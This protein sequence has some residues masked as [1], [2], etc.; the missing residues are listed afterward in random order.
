MSLLNNL[1]NYDEIQVWHMKISY[2]LWEYP[3]YGMY[4]IMFYNCDRII[5][6]SRNHNVS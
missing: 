1:F 2:S 4:Y 6:F 5:L 3:S